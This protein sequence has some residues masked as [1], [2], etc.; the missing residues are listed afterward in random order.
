[1]SRGSSPL[2]FEQPHKPGNCCALILSRFYNWEGVWASS[3]CPLCGWQPRHALEH[4]LREQESARDGCGF[5]GAVG[6][7]LSSS[8]PVGDTN[9][10]AA[11]LLTDLRAVSPTSGHRVGTLLPRLLSTLLKLGISIELAGGNLWAPREGGVAARGPGAQGCVG[12]CARQA[13]I[14]A[15]HQAASPHLPHRDLSE[16]PGQYT[17]LEPFAGGSC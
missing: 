15:L 1:M 14:S 12:R 6:S 11:S 4:W 10:L 2:A 8:A 5:L 3:I 7:A 17:S 9:F 16:S 13:S